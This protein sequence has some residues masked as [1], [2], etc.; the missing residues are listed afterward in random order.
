MQP[1]RFLITGGSQGIGAALAEQACAAGHAVV[2]SGRDA[3]RL[4]DV[5]HRTGAR[6]VQADVGKPDDNARVV[7]ECVERMGGIDVLVNNAGYAYR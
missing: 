5:A 1:R 7:A 4:A 3:R 6:T 2:V